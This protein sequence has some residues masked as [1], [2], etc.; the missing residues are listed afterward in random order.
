LG[1]RFAGLAVTLLC[2]ASTGAEAATIPVTNTADNGAGSLRATIASAANGDTIDATGVSGAITLTSGELLITN[3]LTV[4]GPGPTNLAINGNFP[5]TTNGVLIVSG[6][7]TVSLSGLAMTNGHREFGGGGILNI[8]STLTVSNCT[9][10][11]NSADTVGGGLL[12]N[13]ISGSANV[14]II[15]SIL[16]GNSAGS[17]AVAGAGGAIYNWGEQGHSTLILVGSIISSNSAS[18]GAGIK[19]DGD[20]SGNAMAFITNS[21][22][23]GNSGGDGGGL[24]NDGT[25]STLNVVDS[26]ISSNSASKGGGIYQNDAFSAGTSLVRL[27]N[28]AVSGNSSS[29][30]GGGIANGFIG[31]GAN[32]VIL[33]SST[34]SSN[35]APHGANLYNVSSSTNAIQIGNTILNTGGTG[36]NIVTFV[37]GITSLGYNLSSDDGGGFLTNATDQINTNPLLGPLQD[38]GGPVFTHALLAGSPAID[39]GKNLSGDATDARGFPRTFDNPF[40]ANAVGGDGTDIGAFEAFEI[41]ITAAEKI[42]GDLRL[43]FTSLPGMKYELQSRSDSSSEVWSPLPGTIP[44]NGG[45]AQ[46]TVTNAF[47]QPQQFYQVHQLP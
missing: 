14:T 7:V 28:T 32:T 47:S 39:Q 8:K 21:T 18:L 20:P 24:Y 26:T 41:L 10:A 45:I 11:G 34:F 2:F 27:I 36:T 5:N 9:I 43:S 3:S 31:G 15:N 16:S 38:N 22:I 17:A 33:I 30:Y 37:G 4:I 35:S 6:G 46:A 40:I 13:G 1:G 25:G 19:N 42:G 44:G 12:I 29:G 23:S